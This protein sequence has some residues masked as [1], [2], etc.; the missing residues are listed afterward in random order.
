MLQQ[1]ALHAPRRHPRED[2]EPEQPL[3]TRQHKFTSL[4]G[5][6]TDKKL[7]GI[8]ITGNIYSLTLGSKPC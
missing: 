7:L 4:G 3:Q 6:V 5:I 2:G 8:S 1:H